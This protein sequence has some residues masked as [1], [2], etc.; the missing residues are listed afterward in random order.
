MAVAHDSQMRMVHIAGA[1]QAPAMAEAVTLHV[2]ELPSV[3][4]M[5]NR[6]GVARAGAPIRGCG[7]TAGSG[8]G[9][10]AG[11]IAEELIQS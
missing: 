6:L 3:G 5:S 9:G 7:R 10:G 2:A 8:A 1:A 4:T 11:D